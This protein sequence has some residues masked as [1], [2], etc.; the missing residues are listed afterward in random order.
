MLQEQII[1]LVHDSFFGRNL[2]HAITLL[3]VPPEVFA[4]GIIAQQK[5]TATGCASHSKPARRRCITKR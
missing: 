1:R 5:S 2:Q 4:S 3:Q